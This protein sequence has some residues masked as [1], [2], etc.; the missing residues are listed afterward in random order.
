MTV[1]LKMPALSPTMEK[2]TLAK[3]LVAEGDLIKTGDLI[4]EV[5]TDKATMEVEASDAGRLTKLVVAEGTSDVQVGAV[6]A[7]ITGAEESAEAVSVKSPPSAGAEAPAA[8]SPPVETAPR[9]TT[10]A[11]VST[12]AERPPRQR[13]ADRIRVSPLAS[14]IA[15]AK[16]ID[17]SDI[18][19]TGP[20]GRIVRADLGVSLPSEA[21]VASATPP[22]APLVAALV[23]LPPEGVPVTT[24]KLS[25]MRRTIARRLTESKQ[26]VPHFYLTIRCNLDPLLALRGE[27][28]AALVQRGIKLS[29]NDMVM[30][31]MAQSLIA[32]PDA[33][34][35][36]GGDDLH[37]FG[38][39]DIAMAVA[40]DG[41]LITPV[42][43]G[44]DTLSLSSIAQASKTLATKARDGKL[45]PEDYQGGTVS[46]SNLGMF[47]IDEMV[48][49]I[50]PPQALIL[51]VGAGIEQ[52]W[53][54][55][56]E[57][58]LATVVALTASFD[59]RAI[60]GAV[61]AHFMQSLREHIAD[62]L[63]LCS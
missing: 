63:L 43:R 24:A 32:V 52:P 56:S 41:G 58:A 35:Q 7:L 55:G 47:G 4:A 48:P 3:W 40:I 33:N 10:P 46:I 12:E 45:L 22:A 36:F 23:S 14:R 31:A 13:P 8:V 9:E 53:K 62:P 19:G 30:K 44:V 37:R 28:N 34:V 25:G 1:Q 50:N 16:G 26:T 57:I 59:H 6:I 42:I 38:R 5:E 60:D 51:G 2:G 61:A 39:V 11:A 15:H 20:G 17:L 49:V 27:L 21:L 54:V 29:V 18:R